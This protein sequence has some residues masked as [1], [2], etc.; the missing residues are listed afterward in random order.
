MTGIS[1]SQAAHTVDRCLELASAAEGRA[2]WD[3]A[4]AAYHDVLVAARSTHDRQLV[5]RIFRRIARCHAEA[6]EWGPAQECV[7]VARLTAK[8]NSD[9]AGVAHADNLEGI[10][11]QMRG[12]LL[13]AERQYRIALDSARRTSDAGL[14]AMLHQNLGTL[15]SIRGEHRRA[16]AQYEA[17][18]RGYRA[19]GINRQVG[20]L[21][22]CLGMLHTRLG[23]W[24]E[25]ERYFTDAMR[26]CL[27]DAN[28]AGYWRARAN[29]AEMF[30]VRKRWK[31]AR[32]ECRRILLGARDDCSGPWIAE[33]YKLLGVVERE[34]GNPRSAIGHLGRALDIAVQREDCLLEAE[35]LREMASA[36]HACEEYR[37]TLAALNRSHAIFERLSARPDLSDIARRRG[38]LETQFLRLVHEW[39]S[40]I[41][42]ADRYTQGHCERV[43]DLACSLAADYGIEESSMLWFR[44]GALLHDVGK[45]TIPIEVLNKAG[46]LTEREF[47]QMKLHPVA[48]E[49]LLAGVEFP[50]DVKPMVRHHH[51]RWDG[52][53]YPDQLAGEEIPLTARILCIAD[54]YDALTTTRSYR[55]AYSPDHAA[56]IMA[57]ESARGFDPELLA[58][59]LTKTL[60][61]V[62]G[63]EVMTR[64][65]A[66][67]DAA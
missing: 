23:E 2:D 51:E 13:T 40:S 50:W 3:A 10:I 53:G 22:D 47:E 36:H 64:D 48:G 63:R 34:C 27:A 37:E 19:L 26:T 12:D 1:T 9:L 61:R 67:A 31:K 25:A 11:A 8:A 7:E 45:I 35:V 42:S 14:L 44:M 58:L 43:A 33:T 16:R 6:S 28:K 17:S 39:G 52:R 56:R 41:E 18:L 46:P 30:V 29:R 5:A 4:R 60:P 57:S 65:G 49:V 32:S 62:L 21:L 54:V 38:R 59:F 66:F 15:A 24:P 55:A 20:G